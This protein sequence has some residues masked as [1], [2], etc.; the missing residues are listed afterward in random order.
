MKRVKEWDM[1]KMG[2]HAAHYVCR[3]CGGKFNHYVGRG[4]EFTL[5]VWPRRGGE[6]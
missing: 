2:Y 1:P 4:K 3:S 6:R 5:R